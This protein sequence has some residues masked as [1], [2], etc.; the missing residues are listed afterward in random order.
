MGKHDKL[1]FY[2][3]KNSS[4]LLGEEFNLKRKTKL[5]NQKVDLRGTDAE[6]RVVIVEI[7]PKTTKQPSDNLHEVVG[8]I[9]NYATKFM[10]NEKISGLERSL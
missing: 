1:E 6:D 10:K 8:Q 9:L 7:K 5:N 2:V 4:K 3:M